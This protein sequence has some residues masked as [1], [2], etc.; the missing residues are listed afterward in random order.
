MEIS[1]PSLRTRSA[2][3]RLSFD[4]L[5]L[6]EAARENPKPADGLREKP[7]CTLLSE[8][9]RV[10]LSDGVRENSPDAG[11][12]K[13]G[14]MASMSMLGDANFKFDSSCARTE[15]RLR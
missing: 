2:C 4:M 3:D 14:E 7:L 9:V 11:C 5:L 15:T 13:L 10:K 1:R 8:A 6:F 12:G